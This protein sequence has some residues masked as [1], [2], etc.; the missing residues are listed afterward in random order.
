VIRKIYKAT[1]AHI[2]EVLTGEIKSRNKQWDLIRALGIIFV[3][4]GHNYQPPY[5]FY[6]A[7]FFHMGLFFFISGYFFV[8]QIT[9]QEKFKYFLKK[10]RRQLIPY[11]FFNLLFGLMCIWLKMH[12][13]NLGGDLNFYNMFLAPFE[14]GDQFLLYLA[15]W[16]LLNLYFVSI[17][18]GLVFQKSV[19]VN[20]AIIIV[21]FIIML[22]CLDSY[23]QSNFSISSF[24]IRSIFGFV[25]LGLGYLFRLF[26]PLIQSLLIRPA[27]MIVLYLAVDILSANF[28]S[29][30]YSIRDGHV[31]NNIV[32]VPVIT[33]FCIILMVYII[34]FYVNKVFSLNNF[35]YKIGRHSGSIM[36]WH[37]FFFF[38]VNVIFY[39][40]SLVYISDLSNA[41]FT[42]EIQKLWLIYQIP[43]IILPVLMAMG[44]D[45]FKRKAKSFLLNYFYIGATK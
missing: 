4:W 45:S 9:I 2:K 32:I 6:P 34:T 10:T 15:A 27:T 35:V 38:I 1:K 24:I 42:Y 31:N 13:I 7:F 28:G 39:L 12:Q 30:W 44:Y 16:F 33:T 5:I 21:A 26:E 11:L 14:R 19:K 29:I 36:I 8:P 17:F 3:V 20:I 40:H 23:N 37:L 25:F 22:F 41:F 18:A 43:A